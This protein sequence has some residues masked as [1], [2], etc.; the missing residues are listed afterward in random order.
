MKK[1]ILIINV[2]FFS[3]VSF[4]Q[5]NP[6]VVDITLQDSLFNLWP[7]T[8]EN[9]PIAQVD[10][11]YE[12]NVQIKTPNEVGEVTGYPYLVDV[13]F[14]VLTDVSG[15][16]IDSIQL[17]EVI[18][19]PDGMSLY[20]SADNATYL[21]DQVG[22][23]TLYGNTTAEMIGT[24][25][26]TFVVNGWVTVPVLDVVVALDEVGDLEEITGYRFVVSEDG[27]AS[28]SSPQNN[29]F[30]LSQNVPNPFKSSTEIHFESLK[31]EQI[32]FTVVDVF[33]KTVVE[34][35]IQS[36]TGSN[37]IKLNSDKLSSGLYFYSISNGVNSQTKR[38]LVFKK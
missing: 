10:T 6:C 29:V 35:N 18:G 3:V 34:R 36:V 12:T 5:T 30:A 14:P 16:V 7:D 23:V 28:I 32:N 31:P 21:G 24:H 13:G 4:A 8:V 26:I 2:M 38:M 22:C 37:K 9:L 27:T 17:V 11:Y 20:F 25:P 15:F 33:G 19:L 1:I